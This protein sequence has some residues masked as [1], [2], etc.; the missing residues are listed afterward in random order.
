MPGRSLDRISLRARERGL[1]VGGTDT[2]KST[3]AEALM[4]EFY[5]RYGS[6]RI[7][8]LDSKPRFRAER[9]HHGRPAKRRYRSWSHGPTVP[10][11]VVVATP[12]QL[13][14]AWSTGARIAI[15]QGVKDRDIPALLACA[16]RFLD[17]SRANRPQLL[18]VDETMDFFS[19]NGAPRGGDDVLVRVARAGRER[20]TSALY[21]TQRTRGIPAQLMEELSRCYLFRLDYKADVKRLWEMGFPPGVEP[22][23]VR[24]SF[25]YWTKADYDRVYGPYKL[26]LTNGASASAS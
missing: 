4:V 7:L 12:D 25:V 24:H 21:C 26:D 9:D 6:S 3:L 19:P 10:N 18:M 2:G 16:R 20:G 1:L 17:T 22:P 5:L 11:S 23:T 8:I 14:T 13:D 15:A